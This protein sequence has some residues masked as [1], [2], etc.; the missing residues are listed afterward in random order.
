MLSWW[1]KGRV[2]HDRRTR[3]KITERLTEAGNGMTMTVKGV[4]VQ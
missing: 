2:K 4:R 3:H 1:E